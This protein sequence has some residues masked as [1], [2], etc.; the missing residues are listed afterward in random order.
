MDWRPPRSLAERQEWSKAHPWIAACWFGVSFF[1]ILVVVGL[2][3]TT[4]W[5]SIVVG[6]FVSAVAALLFAPLL[7]FATKRHWGEHPNATTLPPPTFKR[8]W[9]RASDRFLWWAMIL[10]ALAV[11]VSATDLATNSDH[12]ARALIGL[13]AASWW[14][15]TSW[16]ERRQRIAGR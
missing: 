8:M 9:S 13:I 2:E 14:V 1:P 6:V 11:L 7:K 15:A 12:L 4:L 5:R 16:L 10:G 3:R